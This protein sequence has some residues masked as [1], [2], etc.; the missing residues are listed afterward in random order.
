MDTT[1]QQTTWMAVC[2]QR[3]DKKDVPSWRYKEM[4]KTNGNDESEAH[5]NKPVVLNSQ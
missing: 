4:R 5:F 1:I 2:N 3:C